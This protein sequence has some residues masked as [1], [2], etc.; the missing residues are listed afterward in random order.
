M[1]AL[2]ALFFISGMPALVYQ[3]AWQRSLFAIYGINI[4]SVTVVVTAFMLGL[5]LGSLLGGV[6]SRQR[7]MPRLVLFGVLE[8][9]IGLF[10]L[11]SLSIFEWVAVGT[12]GRAPLITGLST[13]GLLLL[14]TLLM[15]A[16][17]PVLTAHLVERSRHVGRSV[18]LLYFANTLGSGV[19]CFV[20]AFVLMGALGLSGS[21]LVAAAGNI[22][23]GLIAVFGMARHRVSVAAPDQAPLSTAGGAGRLRLRAAS[24]LAA[25]SGFLALA[26]EILWF[27]AFSYV[28]GGAAQCFAFLLGAYLVGLAFGSLWSS[29]LTREGRANLH[30][31]AGFALVANVLGVLVIPLLAALVTFLHYSA[32]LPL[33]ALAAAGL[34]GVFPLICHAALPPDARAGQGLSWLYLSNIV[35]AALGSFLTG[36]VFFDQFSLVQVGLGL[37]VLGLLGCVVIWRLGSSRGAHWIPAGAVA[38]VAVVLLAQGPLFGQLYERLHY[39]H[40]F[41]GQRYARVVETRSGV[42]A[43]THD[44][45]VYGGGIYDGRFNTSLENDTNRIFRL[46]SLSALHRDPRRVLVIGLGSGSWTQVIARHPQ[47]RSIDVVE[48]NPGYLDIIDDSDVVRGILKD[49]KTTI[50]IDDGRRWL[51]SHPDERFDLIVMNT[52]FHWRAH[53]TGLLSRDFLELARKHLNERGVL[54]YNATSSPEVFVTGARTFEHALRID[55][56]LA[57][58]DRPFPLDEK[59]W[60]AMLKMHG[61][62]H[63]MSKRQID[64]VVGLLDT[65]RGPRR[66]EAR[67]MEGKRSLLERFA[68]YPTITDDNMATEWRLRW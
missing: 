26:Y 9:G 68:R 63:V 18:G 55:S 1:R 61:T 46:Y 12:A 25:W 40:E 13:F 22:A 62:P 27:R 23:V 67:A 41:E 65:M 51:R 7:R 17:L 34:G 8:I 37:A 49:P 24:V 2:A 11:A 53:A 50:H 47:V 48:I 56:F 10:G 3:I 45:I 52:T 36:Y 21:V 66:T 30:P 32:A 54:F 35:G 5:G 4:E 31:I 58:S 14:P 57:V 39:K 42:V 16:T 28:S 33:V 44:D 43:V 60:R 20:A 6:L 59:H 15:G 38:A 29:R 19:A 64:E